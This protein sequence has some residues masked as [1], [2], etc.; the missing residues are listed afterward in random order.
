[1]VYIHIYL[2]IG[3]HIYIRTY[4][5]TAYTHFKRFYSSLHV[6][7]IPVWCFVNC[8]H[9][10]FAPV[11]I[12]IQ[13]SSNIVSTSS[14][15]IQKEHNYKIHSFR[16][17]SWQPH[18]CTLTLYLYISMPLY[19]SL[20]VSLSFVSFLF[21]LLVPPSPNSKNSCEQV[22]IQCN[23]CAVNIFKSDFNEF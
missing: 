16:E 5:Y 19:M 15:C 4:I 22:L 23:V 6:Q 7:I 10:P 12:S 11:Y 18:S 8:Q 13:W 14:I 21:L 17:L 1:M 20:S 9:M 2:H 3:L